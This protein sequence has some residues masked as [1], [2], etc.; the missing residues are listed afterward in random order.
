MVYINNIIMRLL[1]KDIKDLKKNY[2][3]NLEIYKKDTYNE[4]ILHSDEGLFLVETNNLKKFEILDKEL[5]NHYIN[6]IEFIL[7]KSIINYINSN[8][9]PY[10]HV[11]INKRIN[12]YSL[13]P[14]SNLHLI[15]EFIDGNIFNLYF[16]IKN[17]NIND[18]FIQDELYTFIS[19]LN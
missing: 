1:V 3:Q 6:N 15:L 14:K 12:K 7:D 16:L 8:K 19:L 5:S 13:N 10:N 4:K 18:K 2:L 9:I 11:I 17:N